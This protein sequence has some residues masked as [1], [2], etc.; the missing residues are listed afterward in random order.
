MINEKWLQPWY[1]N[2]SEHKYEKY[3]SNEAHYLPFEIRGE[4]PAG[5][6]H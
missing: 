1:R 4:I 6:R 3:N 5:Y 2:L